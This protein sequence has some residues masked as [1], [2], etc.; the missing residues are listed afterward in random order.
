MWQSIALQLREIYF[1][2]LQYPPNY[3][4]SITVWF[5]QNL[6]CITYHRLHQ[7][8][9]HAA[10]DKAPG[11]QLQRE[12]QSSCWRCLGRQAGC[13]TYIVIILTGYW[14]SRVHELSNY[15]KSTNFCELLILANLVNYCRT[16]WETNGFIVKTNKK[17]N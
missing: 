9:M 5:Y 7:Q 10:V 12:L 3:I 6:G 4:L 16:K 13:Y 2:H 11:E 1:Q 8:S 14:C 17:L 15:C